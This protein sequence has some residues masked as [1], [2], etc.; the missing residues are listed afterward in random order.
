M[1]STVYH[2][3]YFQYPRG[4]ELKDIPSI[5][6]YEIDKTACTTFIITN[7]KYEI[8]SALSY[9]FLLRLSKSDFI[10][11]KKPKN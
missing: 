7:I 4:S 10:S 11:L 5:L 8:P 1:K 3:S 9:Y 6:L 2:F